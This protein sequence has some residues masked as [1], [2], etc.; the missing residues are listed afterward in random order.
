MYVKVSL[1]FYLVTSTIGN[2]LCKPGID[3]PIL[4]CRVSCIH[5]DNSSNITLNR[6]DG[7][8]AAK[9][10]EKNKDMTSCCCIRKW[11]LSQNDDGKLSRGKK[12]KQEDEQYKFSDSDVRDIVSILNSRQNGVSVHIPNNND[13]VFQI[14][15]MLVPLKDF[16][17]TSHVLM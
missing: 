1:I 12:R 13:N 3:T 4:S 9:V 5:V 8:E 14:S 11:D 16:K 17:V 2:Q 10:E 7:G 15:Y 6:I